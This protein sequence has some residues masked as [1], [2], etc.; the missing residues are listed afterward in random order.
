MKRILLYL[1]IVF[2]LTFCKSSNSYQ[3][4]EMS[5]NIDKIIIQSDSIFF[6]IDDVAAIGSIKKI[7]MERKRELV[8]FKPKYWIETSGSECA[9]K[10]GVSEGY[11]K[12]DGVTFLLK[13]NLEEVVSKLI[14]D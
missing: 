4:Y 3:N 13:E 1:P 6:E 5:C 7:L 11:I 8:K 10:I 9:Y 2:F 12:I 14:S